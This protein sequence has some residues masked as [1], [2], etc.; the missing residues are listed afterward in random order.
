MANRYKNKDIV[1]NDSQYY[2]PLRRTRGLK[3]VTQYGTV[4]MRNPSVG[5]RAAVVTA[6]H[7]WKYGDR[8]YNLAARFYGEPEYWWIIAWWN[9]YGVEADIPTGALL[10][11]PTD[12]EQALKALGY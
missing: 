11:I 10:A 7:I 3:S 1:I 6:A 12:I 5:V 8:L 2:A 9:G 4:K